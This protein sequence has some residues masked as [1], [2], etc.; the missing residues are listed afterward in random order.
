MSQQL[1]TLISL[2][3]FLLVVT[4]GLGQADLA[5]WETLL[6]EPNEVV[7]TL[8]ISC[9]G[10]GLVCGALDAY[11]DVQVATVSGSGEVDID[12]AAGTLQFQQNGSQDVGAGL[13]SAYAQVDATDLTFAEIPFIGEPMTESGVVFALSNPLFSA[14]GAIAPGSYPLSAVVSYSALADIVGPVDAWV[15]EIVVTPQDVTV[16]GTLFVLALLPNGQIY[17]RLQDLTATMVV[18]NPTTLLGESV[19][20]TVTAEMTLNLTGN[21]LE[22]VPA[23]GLGGWGL[24]IVIAVVGAVGVA[25]TRR[26]K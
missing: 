6:A 13:Q 2:S 12:A 17:Y 3:L 18:S 15:P 25:A 8:D 23:P 4:P 21:T 11:E 9:V 22:G 19:T 5:P 16:D 26:E 7:Y 14:G 1:F 24:A 10:G 20:V